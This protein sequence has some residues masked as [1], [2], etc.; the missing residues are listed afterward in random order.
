MLKKHKWTGINIQ[1]FNSTNKDVEKF[2]FT[3]CKL[4]AFSNENKFILVVSEITMNAN[5]TIKWKI[6]FV[7]IPYSDLPN[8]K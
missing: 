8:S 2:V 4:F 7:Q 5:V 6:D 3:K 1:N